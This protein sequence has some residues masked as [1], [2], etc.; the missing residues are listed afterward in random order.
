[1]PAQDA[2]IHVD[3][4]QRS[5][6]PGAARGADIIH[7]ANLA[8]GEQLLLE[9]HGEIDVPLAANDLIFI[10]GGEVFS[11]AAAGH[12][13]PDNPVR[14]NALDFKLNDQLVTSAPHGQVQHA[15]I[16]AEDMKALAGDPGCDLW[17]D[18]EG[19]ADSIVEDGDRIIVQPRDEFF[20]VTRDHEDRFYDVTVLLDGEDKPMRFP[21]EM[22]VQQAIK[23][24]L[25][26]SDRPSVGEFEM[27]DRA[28]GPTAL[29][30]TQSLRSAGV[31]DG[32]TLSITKKH[33]GGGCK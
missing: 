30:P 29:E 33:G 10:R 31:R 16:L 19:V 11:I 28:V 4:K 15:K 32:H 27:V 18:L 20:T 9:V 21:A 25:P 1:M 5:I 12:S 2:I 17:G 23:R 7:L 3:R 14:R 13:L 22:T 26:K 24:S 8:P 6:T